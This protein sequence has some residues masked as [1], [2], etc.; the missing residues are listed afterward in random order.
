MGNGD[1]DDTGEGVG[2][3][4]KVVDAVVKSGAQD[5]L[6]ALPKADFFEGPGRTAWSRRFGDGR[7]TERALRLANELADMVT[8]Q[9][10]PRVPR[11]Q[12]SPVEIVEE[13]KRLHR[14]I[15]A[16]WVNEVSKNSQPYID[17]FKKPR[18]NIW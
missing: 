7:K 4:V 18:Q 8:E 12:R 17:F 5:D 11:K 15:F 13:I 10:S 2:I 3:G 6:C 9:V 14:E 1:G 16:I